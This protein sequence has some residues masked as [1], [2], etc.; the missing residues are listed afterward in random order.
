MTE[1][2]VCKVGEIDEG[3]VLLVGEAPKIGVF[4]HRGEYY[5]Y[6]NECPHQGGPACEGLRLPK[7]LDVI[8]ENGLFV[9]QDYDEDE[10]HIVCPWHGYEYRLTTGEHAADSRLKLQRHEVILRDGEIY[11]QI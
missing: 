8:D 11:V 5:A 1:I 7:V 9:R 6:R 10:M 4:L 2:F 3:H